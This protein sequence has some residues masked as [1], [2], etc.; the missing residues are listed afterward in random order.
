[1]KINWIV[2][3]I[4]AFCVIALIVYVVKQNRKD[5]EDLTNVLNNDF[6][7]EEASEFNDED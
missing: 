1:M 6:K 4:V 2:I 3:A 7:K 5:K